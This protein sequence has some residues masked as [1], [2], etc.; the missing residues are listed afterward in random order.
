[1]ATSQKKIIEELRNQW[2]K[3]WREKL[4]DK[5]RAEGVAT[6]DYLSLFVEKGTIIK[7]TKDFKA[8]NLKE[9]IEQYQFSN[10][11]RILPPNPQEGGWN[12]FIKTKVL[13]NHKQKREDFTFQLNGKKE[14]QHPKK[15]GR[16]WLHQ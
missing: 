7:A 15:G 16:G 10:L 4:D 8:L 11:E 2:K 9:I 12:K 6:K 5:I 1:V 3:L 13:K 14:K